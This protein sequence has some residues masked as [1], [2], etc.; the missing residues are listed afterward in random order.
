MRRK[1][2]GKI[3]E[4]G[5]W[6]SGFS[7][8]NR[9]KQLVISSLSLFI[10]WTDSDGN[11]GFVINLDADGGVSLLDGDVDPFGVP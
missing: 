2:L 4:D 5:S 11:N 9:K 7:K 8:K 3:E 6:S 10:L 1:L